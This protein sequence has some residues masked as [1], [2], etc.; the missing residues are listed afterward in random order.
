[1]TTIARDGKEGYQNG[2][3]K[4]AEFCKPDGIAYTSWGTD[5]ILN[6]TDYRN[7][8]IGKLR[9]QNKEM[10][11]GSATQMRQSYGG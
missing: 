3:G 5:N 6:V 7:N 4:N 1:V 2:I 10:F 11:R 8:L 9:F